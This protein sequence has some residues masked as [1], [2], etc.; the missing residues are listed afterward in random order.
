MADTLHAPHPFGGLVTI[1]VSQEFGST[2]GDASID[3]SPD[4]A[5]LYALALIRAA[6]EADRQDW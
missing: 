1:S 4:R 3:V 2:L 5:R 6:D